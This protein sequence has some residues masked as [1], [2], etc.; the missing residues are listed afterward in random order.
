MQKQL[1]PQLAEAKLAKD[2]Y[3]ILTLELKKHNK[4]LQAA[5]KDHWKVSKALHRSNSVGAITD[6][7]NYTPTQDDP[8]SPANYSCGSILNQMHHMSQT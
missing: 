6:K 8:V 7:Q 5:E 3:Q 2:E 4:N 1:E